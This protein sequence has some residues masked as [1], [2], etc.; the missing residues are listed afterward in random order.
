MSSLIKSNN[1]VS[2]QTPKKHHSLLR[3]L[4]VAYVTTALASFVIV[5][6][7][8]WYARSYDP[9]LTPRHTHYMRMYW[10]MRE[11]FMPIGSLGFLAGL[12]IVLSPLK[13]KQRKYVWMSLGL[14]ALVV[15]LS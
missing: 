14:F 4:F 3:L 10:A 11:L 6:G 12:F 15:Y 2:P 13:W 8:N 1:T 9:W 5:L 7:I